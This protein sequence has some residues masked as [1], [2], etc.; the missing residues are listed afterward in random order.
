M[1]TTGSLVVMEMTP[2]MM[3]GVA[4]TTLTAGKGL[5]HYSC[6]QSRLVLQLTFRLGPL[7]RTLIR[8]NGLKLQ[9]KTKLIL[10]NQSKF[11]VA[12]LMAIP[13]WVQKAMKP[14][15]DL[16]VTTP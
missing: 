13:L 12:H 9:H 4:M 1:V 7:S 6:Q 3:T 16:M 10:L 5:T 15:M 2:F 14:F 8:R 11:L